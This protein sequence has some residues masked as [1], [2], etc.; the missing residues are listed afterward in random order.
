MEALF[1]SM[2]KNNLSLILKWSFKNGA[3]MLQTMCFFTKL[4]RKTEN[5]LLLRH[6]RIVGSTVKN[7]NGLSQEYTVSR[8]RYSK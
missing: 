2:E 6:G 8:F 1:E 5:S 3:K 7:M 4:G